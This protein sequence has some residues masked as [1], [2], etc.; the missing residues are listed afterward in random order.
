MENSFSKILPFV[1]HPSDSLQFQKQLMT[2]SEKR[3]GFNIFFEWF[4][5]RKSLIYK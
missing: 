4:W 3:F 1:T 2:K 5:L